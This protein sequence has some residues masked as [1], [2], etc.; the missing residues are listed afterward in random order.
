MMNH[1]RRATV[2][3]L[4]AVVDKDGWPWHPTPIFHLART[5]HARMDKQ[6]EKQRPWRLVRFVVAPATRKHR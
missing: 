1:A 3:D 5:E 2:R 6:Y 4:W